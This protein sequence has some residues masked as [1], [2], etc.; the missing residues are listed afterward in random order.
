MFTLR[1][2]ELASPLN[3]C[4]KF[5]L[6][7]ILESCCCH[8]WRFVATE[9]LWP[10][11]GIFWNCCVNS[12]VNAVWYVSHQQAWFDA[13]KFQYSNVVSEYSFN[14]NPHKLFSLSLLATSLCDCSVY[15]LHQDGQFWSSGWGKVRLG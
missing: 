7:L 9:M 10:R 1:L 15:L 3:A 2:D 5:I 11:S 14:T 8:P 4:S 6:I 13:C 12:F